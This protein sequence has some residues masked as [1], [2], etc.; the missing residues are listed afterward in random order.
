MHGRITSFCV[1]KIGV[2]KIGRIGVEPRFRADREIPVRPHFL[3]AAR[4]RG[5]TPIFLGNW[6]GGFHRSKAGRRCPACRN[7]GAVSAGVSGDESPSI[8][9]ITGPGFGHGGQHAD[10]RTSCCACRFVEAGFAESG[11]AGSS[12]GGG[13]YPCPG[14]DSNRRLSS[15]STGGFGGLCRNTGVEPA[16]LRVSVVCS[17]HLS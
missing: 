7:Q 11:G 4:N 9:A 12:R 5:S 3:V 8:G 17:T 10:R 13:Q 2:E 15:L 16:T 14:A 6:C 1:E